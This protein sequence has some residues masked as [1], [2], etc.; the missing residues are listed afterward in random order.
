MRFKADLAR[1][2]RT[3]NYVAQLVELA[4]AELENF[5]AFTKLF[6]KRLK[7]ISPE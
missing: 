4:D 5:A 6:S 3:Y 1:F 2:V 7:G